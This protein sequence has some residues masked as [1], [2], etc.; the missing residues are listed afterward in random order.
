MLFCLANCRYFISFKRGDVNWNVQKLTFIHF[1]ICFSKA[2]AHS[3]C[4]KTNRFANTKISSLSHNVSM[5]GRYS[6]VEVC[7]GKMACR[8][9]IFL[10][11]QA[12]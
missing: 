8:I 11:S 7:F 5:S 1:T 4:I 6:I 9:N 10:T 3:N 12:S 2:I